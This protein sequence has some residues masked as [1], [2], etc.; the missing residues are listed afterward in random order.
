MDLGNFNGSNLKLVTCVIHGRC[1]SAHTHRLKLILAEKLFIAKVLSEDSLHR[2]RNREVLFL[3]CGH[4]KEGHPARIG[5]NQVNLW[6]NEFWLSPHWSTS[7]TRPLPVRRYDKLIKQDTA[8]YDNINTDSLLSNP[9][10]ICGGLNQEFTELFGF[11]P[12]KA[13]E[14]EFLSQI[15]SR[16]HN[17]LQTKDDEIDNLHKLVRKLEDEIKRK[18]SENAALVSFPQLTFGKTM[19]RNEL[20]VLTGIDESLF[21]R[22]LLFYMSGKNYNSNMV[23]VPEGREFMH[24]PQEELLWAL[25]YA[26]T[27]DT[28]H[29]IARQASVS[30]IRVRSAVLEVFNVLKLALNSETK[31]PSAEVLCSE[32]PDEGLR[33]FEDR[34]FFAVDATVV[35]IQASRDRSD[36]RDTY[37]S[38]GKV[39][40]FKLFIICATSG[41]IVGVSSAMV[42]SVSDKTA[43]CDQYDSM[44]GLVNRFD[45]TGLRPALIGDKGYR[46]VKPLEG[47]DLILTANAE[48]DRDDDDDD[49]EDEVVQNLNRDNVFCT[50]DACAPRVVVERLFGWIKRFKLFTCG[51]VRRS[52]VQLVENA[53]H[54][55]CAL[56]NWRK[57]MFVKDPPEPGAARIVLE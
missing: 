51:E 17:L 3:C 34:V 28:F 45:S 9:L 40:G 52:Q 24:G 15:L 35:P 18:K 21:D 37:S 20:M 56:C 31:L 13:A 16:T 33:G 7:P 4:F 36:N 50:K 54:V 48:Y 2:V 44:L 53:F 46:G 8:E 49:D 39:H 27:A 41:R 11:L 30:I 42:G 10:G 6:L 19:L 29:S 5:R 47:M 32:Q 1:E 25:M 55:A 22:L 26:R 12:P 23:R 38:K 57:G 14:D 43:L